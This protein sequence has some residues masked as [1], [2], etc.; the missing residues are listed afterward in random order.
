MAERLKNQHI[1]FT[2]V[3]TAKT[4]VTVYGVNDVSNTQTN[5]L[6]SY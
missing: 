5:Q 2:D 6:H 4:N 1:Y 3:W